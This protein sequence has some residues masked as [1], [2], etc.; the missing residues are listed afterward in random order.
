MFAY[1]VIGDV[2]QLYI[3][4][5]FVFLMSMFGSLIVFLI[6]QKYLK[7]NVSLFSGIAVGVMLATT[8]WSLLVPAFE[9]SKDCILII[10]SF[11]FGYAV[12]FMFEIVQT[13]RCEKT[14]TTANGTYLAITL[15]NIPEGLII[16]VGFGML[17]FADNSFGAIALALAIGIQN[18]PESISLSIILKEKGFSNKKIFALSLL[19]AIVEPIFGLIGYFLSY[20][21]VNM[22]GA[23]LG[24][25]AGMMMFVLI[26]EMII[27]ALEENKILGMLGI[28]FGFTLMMMLEKIL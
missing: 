27:D 22:L 26:S 19:S 6:D 11:A 4:L 25:T 28:L 16:G 3:W 7:R 10:I 14:Q 12:L 17:Q 15:H 5:M 13:R 23:I 9:Y 8:V 21:I 24:F 18:F 2:M 20:Y 1:N